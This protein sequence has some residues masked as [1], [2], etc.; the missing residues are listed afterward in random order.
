MWRYEVAYYKVID[1][2]KVI[3]NKGFGY[4]EQFDR[5]MR[6]LAKNGNEVIKCYVD[7]WCPEAVEQYAQYL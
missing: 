4:K 6:K 5:F 3:F 2:R 7:R 1:G